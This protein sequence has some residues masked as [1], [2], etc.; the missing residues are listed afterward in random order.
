MA[1]PYPLRSVSLFEASKLKRETLP[2]TVETPAQSMGLFSVVTCASFSFSLSF[3]KAFR[4][5]HDINLRSQTQE[6]DRSKISALAIFIFGNR[7]QDYCPSHYTLSIEL[8]KYCPPKANDRSVHKPNFEHRLRSIQSVL[9]PG[10]DLH[11][12]GLCFTSLPLSLVSKNNA[13]Y[14]IPAWFDKRRHN[15]AFLF[16]HSIAWSFQNPIRFC[17]TTCECFVMLFA[18]NIECEPTNLVKSSTKSTH[19]YVV[20]TLIK[21]HRQKHAAFDFLVGR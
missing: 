15:F 12:L 2:T 7:E 17:E 20:C 10:F 14:F 21:N 8:I 6:R 16:P 13:R 5:R 3:W 11:D 9:P 4:F 18:F 1:L 19:Y